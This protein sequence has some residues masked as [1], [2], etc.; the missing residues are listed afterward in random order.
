MIELAF[1]F[2]QILIKTRPRMRLMCDCV[3]CSPNPPLE[4]AYLSYKFGLQTSPLP[5]DGWES[6]IRLCDIL[7]DSVL[8][9][10]IDDFIALKKVLGK[11]TVEDPFQ[12]DK[13]N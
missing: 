12:L 8:Q 1:A 6:Y 13:P 2:V 3:D 5:R 11:E 10:T 7:T 9:H 4:Q